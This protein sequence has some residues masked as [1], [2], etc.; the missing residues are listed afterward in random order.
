MENTS[1]ETLFMR[2]FHLIFEFLGDCW[3]IQNSLNGRANW[4][5][6]HQAID[7]KLGLILA[8][9]IHPV[10][11]GTKDVRALDYPRG[12]SFRFACFSHARPITSPFM[13][14]LKGSIA[15]CLALISLSLGQ[16]SQ[17]ADDQRAREI[18]DG[19][20]R[21]FVSKSSTATVE[22]QI[23]KEDLQRKITMQFWSVDESN[24]LIRIRSPQEDAGTAILKVG[25]KI[26]YYL[27][28]ANRTVKM[29]HFDDDEPRGWAV[30]S[31]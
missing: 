8:R 4:A 3:P 23:T 28:K 6:F 19:V 17:A 25:G 1:F 14:W 11:S 13:R 9:R 27:P 18:V 7:E 5:R 12:V 29:P 22:M 10:R 31:P 26:W 15:I 24:I 30:I 2:K 21:L 16:V 20:A